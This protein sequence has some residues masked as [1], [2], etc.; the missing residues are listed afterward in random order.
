[1]FK[2]GDAVMVTK[3][4]DH[5]NSNTSRPPIGSVGIVEIAENDYCILNIAKG[6]VYNDE[7]K[8]YNWD[9]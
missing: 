6:G 9:E 2:P 8:L 1:M 5:H 7:L 4:K 3:R